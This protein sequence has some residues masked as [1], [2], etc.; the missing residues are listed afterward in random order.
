MERP[1]STGTKNDVVFFVGDEIEKTPAFGKKT[2][3]VVGLQPVEE[4][5]AMATRKRCDHI[6]FGANQSFSFS[7]ETIESWETMICELLKLDFWVT[8]DFDICDYQSITDSMVFTCAYDRFIPQISIKLPYISNLNYNATIKID[9]QDFRST[10]P[11]VWVHTLHN[12][13]DR[14]VFTDWS[15]YTNDSI[16]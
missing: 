12:L 10:N 9:D 15:K 7:L 1:Y 14:E 13:M 11:G 3:F 16:I 6:Y 8:W 5:V 2:L 4:I